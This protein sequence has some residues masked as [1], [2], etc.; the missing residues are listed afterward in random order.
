MGDEVSKLEIKIHKY[1]LKS[2]TNKVRE[3]QKST[4]RRVYTCT[5]DD[6]KWR[7]INTGLL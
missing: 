7:F 6:F 4:N 1:Y 5:N 3:V 2:L